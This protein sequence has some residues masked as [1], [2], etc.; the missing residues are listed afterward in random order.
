M[1][2]NFKARLATINF[3]LFVMGGLIIF[4]VGR[5]QFS[6]S[7]DANTLRTR[8]EKDYGERSEVI[9]PV[10]GQIYDR[11]GNLLAGNREMFELGV[12]LNQVRLAQN[13][14]TIANVLAATL[15]LKPYDKPHDIDYYTN[16][17]NGALANENSVYLML[18][19]QVSPEQIS[20]IEALVKQYSKNY[21]SKSKTP[22]KDTLA[23][24]TWSPKL[25]RFYPEGDLAGNVL[26]FVTEFNGPFYGVE[27]KY[28]DLLSG[29]PLTTTVSYDPN[30]INN[31]QSIPHGADLV[32]TI[33]RDV[34]LAME[35]ILDQSVQDTGSEGGVII[36]M[37][38]RNGEILAM[39]T[40]PRPNLNEFLTFVN[41]NK[42]FNPA[43][44][45]TYEPGSV[46]KLITMG[47]AIDVGAVTPD[48]PYFDQGYY[49]N[50]GITIRNWNGGA[51]YDQ[52]MTTCMV[53]SL[54]VCLAEM[55]FEKLQQD[56]FYDYLNRFQFNRRTNIDLAGESMQRPPLPGDNGWYLATF[57]TQSFGQGI[58][59]T[60]IQMT[61]A[62]SS[63]ANDGK[64]MAPRVVRSI[65]QDGI[66]YNTQEVVAGMPIK[67][68]TAKTMTEMMAVSVEDEASKAKSEHYRMAGKTGTA[69]V[70]IDGQ[71]SD[72][73][74]NTSFLGWGPVDDPRMLVYIW[75]E[76]PESSEWSS[77]VTAPV[78]KE[79]VEK[80]GV[81]LEIPPDDIRKQ[82]LAQN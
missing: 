35:Q 46:F 67:P 71:Y 18:E 64:M 59:V 45:K 48:T 9:Q 60:P 7:A 79:V 80:L 16:A 23:G 31:E 2:Y 56:R 21:D 39:A 17:F 5:L 66:Q 43:I 53:H 68:E 34:Q 73:V 65:I 26:G 82:I 69:S 44:D 25:M 37:D 78:F 1:K 70:V 14:D 28:N 42:Y 63:L 62:A 11:W 15:Q 81:L 49:Y 13:Q 76:K 57:L 20:Q 33:D 75:L 4:Q 19:N 30:K 51:W 27:E 22:G 12:D 61:M 36:V 3:V 41:N 54:N 55:A 29:V 77:V 52:T 8:I 58:A 40:N 38:P 47:A 74:T 72:S 10:R 6:T 50:G 32:L 24:L